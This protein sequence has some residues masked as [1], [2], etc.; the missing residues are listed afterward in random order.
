MASPFLD[1]LQM[2]REAVTKLESEVNSLATG[3]TK[4]QDVVRALHQFSNVSLGMEAHLREIL[5]GPSERV[6][7]DAPTIWRQLKRWSD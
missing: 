2:W 5:P 1:P 4:S 7:G 3:S 6:S